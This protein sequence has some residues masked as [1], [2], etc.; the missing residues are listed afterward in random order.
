MEPPPTVGKLRDQ[1]LQQWNSPSLVFS[2]C[3]ERVALN[4]AI[5]RGTRNSVQASLFSFNQQESG[6]DPIPHITVRGMDDWKFN[7]LVGIKDYFSVKE[8]T[9]GKFSD[10]ILEDQIRN[11]RQVRAFTIKEMHVRC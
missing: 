6:G 8:S 9:L 3:K 2:D 1:Y 4:R 10:E 11:I 7:K 5:T